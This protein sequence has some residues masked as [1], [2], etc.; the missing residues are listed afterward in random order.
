MSMIKRAIEEYWQCTKKRKATI[1]LGNPTR[2][3]QVAWR[4]F[5]YSIYKIGV[6]TRANLEL[7]EPGPKPDGKKKYQAVLFGN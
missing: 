1:F 6:F 4:L 5:P 7:N 2:Y 3:A